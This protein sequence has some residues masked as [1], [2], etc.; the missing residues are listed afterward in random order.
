MEFLFGKDIFLQTDNPIAVLSS[1]RLAPSGGSGIDNFTDGTDFAEDLKAYFPGKK[2]L[3]DFGTATG[4][5]PLTMR[6]AGMLAVGIEGCEMFK[7]NNEGAWSE[8]P[9]IVRLCDAGKPWRIVDTTGKNIIF[10]F[11]ISWGTVEH[12]PLKDI[13]NTMES[14][15]AHTD[16]NSIIMLNIDL[17]FNPDDWIDENGVH[18]G[19]HMLWENYPRKGQ[20]YIREETIDMLYWILADYFIIDRELE[21]INWR[22]SRP[23]KKEVEDVR[24]AGWTAKEGRSYWWLRKK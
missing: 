21:K 2:T 19:F 15:L 9:D 20:R 7:K 17:G 13:H 5:V 3:L 24:A 16:K 14:I 23:T 12:I 18:R 10:D 4:T 22:Y 8:M 6:K 1:D 11:I